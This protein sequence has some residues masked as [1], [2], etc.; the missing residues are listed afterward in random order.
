MT[1]SPSVTGVAAQYELV[2]WVGSTASYFTTCSQ[3]TLPSARSRHHR[4]RLCPFASSDCA[5]KIRLPH[6]TGAACD[7]SGSA[8]FHLTFCL[9]LQ[10]VGRF[11][12]V[13]LPSPLGPRQPGQLSAAARVAMKRKAVMERRM[14]FMGGTF[15]VRA[16]DRLTIFGLLDIRFQVVLL[17]KFLERFDC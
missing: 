1:R 15:G 12:S 10:V 6:T 4:A 7:F 3:I 9:S 17:G 16:S 2:L 8:I 13:D 11:F 5:R 14:R